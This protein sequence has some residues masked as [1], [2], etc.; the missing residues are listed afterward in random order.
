[1]HG[2]LSLSVFLQKGNAQENIPPAGIYELSS[3]GDCVCFMLFDGRCGEGLTVCQ[4]HSL[5]LQTCHPVKEEREA[6]R[7]T[8]GGAWE[9]A[10][11]TPPP[12]LQAGLPSHTPTR[13]RPHPRGTSAVWTHT[14]WGGVSGMG[15]GA[16]FCQQ[17]MQVSH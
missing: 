10:G 9:P 4:C 11:A 13:H 8:R 14:E 2:A 15:W 12:P 17:S 5:T 7:G 3:S 1:M 6:E 16:P